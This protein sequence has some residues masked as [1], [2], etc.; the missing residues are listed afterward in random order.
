MIKTNN[1]YDL[2]DRTMKFSQNII[3]LARLLKRDVVNNPLINQLVKSGTSIGAN[4][5]EANGA[6][7]KKDF[8]NKIYICKKEARETK[9]WLQIIGQSNQEHRDKC[10]ELWKECQELTL[11]FSKI[12]IT[13]KEKK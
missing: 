6:S 12:T 9:Y 13:L 8:R 3:L 10:R 1:K 4:Y 11:I 5:M 7:S 2:E